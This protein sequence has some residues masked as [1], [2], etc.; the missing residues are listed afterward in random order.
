MLK[1]R[2]NALEAEIGRIQGEISDGSQRQLEGTKSV[3]AMPSSGTLATVVADYEELL[4][5]QEFAEKAYTAALGSVER[6]R[7][8]ADRSQ[9]YL[10]MYMQPNAP[11]QAAYPLRVQNI[12]LVLILAS[13]LWAVGALAFLTARDHVM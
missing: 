6:A 12:F 10:A 11:E 1:S 3:A 4:L 2:I 5:N 8:E 7:S 13:V 9:S